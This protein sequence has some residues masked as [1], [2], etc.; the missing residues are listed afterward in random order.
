MYEYTW[1]SALRLLSGAVLVSGVGVSED[2]DVLAPGRIPTLT[3]CLGEQGWP[4]L[5]A[6]LQAAV[7]SSQT[8]QSTAAYKITNIDQ[9]RF[10]SGPSAA[11]GI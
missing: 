4:V 2:C 3:A 1:A 6:C 8:H 11:T 7:H 5:G 9:A 10:K